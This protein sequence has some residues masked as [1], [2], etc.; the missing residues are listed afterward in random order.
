MSKKE[1]L[2]QLRKI[3]AEMYD[4]RYAGVDGPRLY[5]AQGLV[6][7]YLRALT[8]LGIAD[9]NELIAVVND[10][11]HRAASRADRA[12]VRPSSAP[13]PQPAVDFA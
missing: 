4:A 5:R 12:L 1:V 9:N 3:L 7:G 2:G 6:D 8:H 11:K 10:E 13:L